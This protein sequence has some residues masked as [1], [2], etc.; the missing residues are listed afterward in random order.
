MAPDQASR[1]R[2]N[3]EVEC[4]RMSRLV[5][6]LL[7]LARSDAGTWTIARE[8][9]DM[10]ALLLETAELFC[11]VARQKGQRL[12]LEVPERDLPPVTGDPQRLRQVLSVL[13]DNAFSYTPQGG[14][15]TLRAEVDGAALTLQVADT[16]PGISPQS[17]PYI[18]DR[19]YRADVSR[20]TK[21][22]FGL[23]LSIAKELAALHGGTL[24]V[25]RTGPEGT[26]FA[27]RLPLHRGRHI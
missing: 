23:G 14:V 3:I 6:D 4:A 16:G 13:L 25:A 18:F 5:D 26:V 21:E 8:T 17:L 9:V 20:T 7:S 1:L 22:H 15:V 24:R 2:Q 10:D 12:L 11:P 19:F 27:L